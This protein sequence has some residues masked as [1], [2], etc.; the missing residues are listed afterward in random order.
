MALAKIEAWGLSA[1]GQ[2]IPLF[3]APKLSWPQLKN[4]LLL[5]G[6]M[7]GDEPE[8]VALAESCKTWLE[9]EPKVHHS[10][11]ILIPCINP[12]GYHKNLRTNGHGVDL[13]R[14]FPSHNWSPEAKAPRYSPGPKANSE[15]EIQ[16]L[17]DLILQT[18]P[19]LIIHFHSWKPC[20]VCTGKPARPFA[21]FLAASSKFAIVDDIGYPT[22]GSLSQ[23]AWHDHQIPVICTEDEEHRNPN[24]PWQRFGEG[25]KKIILNL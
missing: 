13:N 24:L 25:L 10:P 15:P 19:R 23:F 7:H 18:R 21:Q 8:G 1:L 4:P 6:G 17:S 16:A 11:W 22:P 5:I 20:I 9:N 3:Y 14:N 2:K 12:D